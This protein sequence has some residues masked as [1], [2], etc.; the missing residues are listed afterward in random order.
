MRAIE[1]QWNPANGFD[2]AAFSLFVE[3]PGKAGGSR[4]MPQQN[5]ELPGGMSW[6]YRLR[7]HGWSNALFSS[8]GADADTEG[9]PVAPSSTIETDRD[10]ATIT[11]TLPA[12][13]LGNLQTLSGVRVYANAWDYDGGYRT[14]APE[15]GRMHFGG[16]DGA[17]DP[18][19]MD[20]TAVIELP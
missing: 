12:A 18:L 17:I 1:A 4:I 20:D 9:T 3:V 19:V 16:G 8:S 2:H 14:L 15:P 5:A 6:H 7:A 11:F 13:A 10:A